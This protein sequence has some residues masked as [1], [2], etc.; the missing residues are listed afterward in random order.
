MGQSKH[1]ALQ[2]REGFFCFPANL[3]QFV[4]SSIDQK[5]GDLSLPTS[6]ARSVAICWEFFQFLG[7]GKEGQVKPWTPRNVQVPDKPVTNDRTRNHDVRRSTATSNKVEVR[8]RL[9]HCEVCKLSTIMG[10]RV[11]SPPLAALCRTQQVMMKSTP[12]AQPGRHR[13]RLLLMHRRYHGMPRKHTSPASEPPEARWKLTGY[14]DLPRTGEITPLPRQ[15]ALRKVRRL[16]ASVVPQ[17]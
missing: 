8:G 4:S 12:Q 14:A 15:P 7:A 9:L 2:S 10:T 5:L 13:G 16:G 6:I 17:V 11:S 3:P 1:S